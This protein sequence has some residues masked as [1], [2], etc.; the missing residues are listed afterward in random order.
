MKKQELRRLVD[1]LLQDY[2]DWVL[3]VRHFR[4]KDI[5]NVRVEVP[6]QFTPDIY[7]NEYKQTS[8][9]LGK[10]IGKYIRVIKQRYKRNYEKL[11]SLLESQ[12]NGRSNKIEKRNIDIL[13]II[14][15]DKPKRVP[16][17]KGGKGKA[18][19]PKVEVEVEEEVSDVEEEGDDYI[20]PYRELVADLIK[21]I[22]DSLVFRNGNYEFIKIPVDK[23]ANKH[24][25]DIE[26]VERY[27][28]RI[29]NKF[30]ISNDE[31]DKLDEKSKYESIVKVT[32]AATPEG[33]SPKRLLNQIRYFKATNT[34]LIVNPD[35][36]IGKNLT[37]NDALRYLH[38]LHNKTDKPFVYTYNLKKFFKADGI[39]DVI[40]YYTRIELTGK[41][42]NFDYNVYLN[43]KLKVIT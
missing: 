37:Y 23:L 4:G 14:V 25:T 29:K 3:I 19:K 33:V 43:G 38:R 6:P 42:K 40:R 1:I 13:K 31:L 28:K 10:E 34:P 17:P 24:R 36:I 20:S 22:Q 41:N 30:F 16:K 9:E 32:L 26:T 27:R 7:S 15:Q 12:I 39:K 8:M 21:L 11:F 5:E 18:S 35:N 2:R